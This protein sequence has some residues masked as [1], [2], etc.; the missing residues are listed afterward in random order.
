MIKK[1]VK[2]IYD[3]SECCTSYIHR[4]PAVT[5]SYPSGKEPQQLTIAGKPFHAEGKG[6]V[7][8]LFVVLYIHNNVSCLVTLSS[9]YTPQGMTD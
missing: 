6:C 3:L 7:Q 4:R 2:G 8:G 5:G 9:Q 1:R